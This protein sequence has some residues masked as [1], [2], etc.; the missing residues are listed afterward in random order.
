M[1]NKV[2]KYIIYILF[3]ITTIRL[4]DIY[5]IKHEEYYLKYLDKTNTLVYGTTA[6]RG[7]ILDI[8]GTILVDNI[9]INNIIYRKINT[10]EITLSKVIGNY[11]TIEEEISTNQLKKYYLSTNNTEY[12]LTDEEVKEYQERKL[13]KEEI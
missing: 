7:R 10:D 11:I 4:I 8:N 6:P 12:L 9:G 1:L 13:S 5:Y 2:I 3:L